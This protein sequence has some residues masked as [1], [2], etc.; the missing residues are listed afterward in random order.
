MQMF[1]F[2]IQNE[3]MSLQF[4][5]LPPPFPQ[6][7]GVQLSV[8]HNSWIHGQLSHQYHEKWWGFLCH[9]RGQ[10]HLENWSSDLGVTG[11][12]KPG[13]WLYWHRGANC[14]LVCG[15]RSGKNVIS[16]RAY[17][18]TTRSRIFASLVSMEFVQ[19]FPVIEIIFAFPSSMQTL[20]RC[21]GL[22]LGNVILSSPSRWFGH[23]DLVF[24][25]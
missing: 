14:K 17:F 5:S 25:V 11:E 7:Q 2:L 1:S 3:R 23:Y 12:G 9:K 22:D 8:P 4:V 24:R 10:L 18:R 21:N 13:S 16:T 6:T 19:K 15:E 20:I